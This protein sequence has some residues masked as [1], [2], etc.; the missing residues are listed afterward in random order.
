M[1]PF[2][3]STNWEYQIYFCNTNRRIAEIFVVVV[4]AAA[5]TVDVSGK[6]KKN[7]FMFITQFSH[8]WP[9]VS[10]SWLIKFEFSR[11]KNC[12]FFKLLFEIVIC[13]NLMICGNVWKFE[14][15]P[16]SSTRIVWNFGVCWQDLSVN[17]AQLGTNLMDHWSEM[18]GHYSCIRLYFIYIFRVMFLY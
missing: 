9:C 13:V 17:T 18:I 4:F 1:A 5:A 6:L 15:P 16:T 8:F 14:N 3:N 12:H 10:N 2:G 7:L 11:T